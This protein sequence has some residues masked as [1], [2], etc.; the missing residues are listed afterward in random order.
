MRKL[1]NLKLNLMKSF[2][3]LEFQVTNQKFEIKFN[4]PWFWLIS[5]P[6]VCCGYYECNA[7]GFYTH[8]K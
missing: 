6:Y 1:Q 3:H 8:V 2:F 7:K 4:L 5:F